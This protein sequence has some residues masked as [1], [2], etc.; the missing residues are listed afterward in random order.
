ML[1]PGTVAY[2]VLNLEL[3]HFSL[4][5]HTL[6]IFSFPTAYVLCM[7]YHNMKIEPSIR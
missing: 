4:T 5:A 7:Q 1:P 2:F 6:C 3:T